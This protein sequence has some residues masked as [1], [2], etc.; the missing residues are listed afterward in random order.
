[1]RNYLTY[2][3]LIDK[4]SGEIIKIRNIPTGFSD[5]DKKKIKD[6]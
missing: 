6:I 4:F 2:L 5:A 3:Q 1:M